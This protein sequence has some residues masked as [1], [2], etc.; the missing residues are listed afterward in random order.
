MSGNLHEWIQDWYS[1]SYYSISPDTDPPGPAAVDV[2]PSPHRVFRG[3]S[4]TSR[5]ADSRVIF[6]DR[7]DPIFRGGYIGFRLVRVAP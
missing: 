4:W 2:F 1:S 7:D 5:A 6:R 3:G